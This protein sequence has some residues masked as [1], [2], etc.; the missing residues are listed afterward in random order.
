MRGRL[1][2]VEFRGKGCE[3]QEEFRLGLPEKVDIHGAILNGR[4]E[5]EAFLVRRVMWAK[6]ERQGEH[7]SEG[8]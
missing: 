6:A 5:V 4:G 3:W 8:W 7:T 1:G 2:G